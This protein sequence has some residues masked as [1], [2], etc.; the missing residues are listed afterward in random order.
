[1]GIRS[2]KFPLD[3][4]RGARAMSARR[5]ST[6]A[7]AAVVFA[8]VAGTATAGPSQAERFTAA[9]DA[10]LAQPYQPNYV[11]LGFDAA[12]DAAV[13]NTAPVQDYTSGSIPGSA[14]HPD[15]PASFRDVLVK[16]ADGT[17][18]TGKLALRPGT[19][20][21]VVVV[22]GFNTNAKESVVRWA[23]MLARN[24]FNVL[25]A[26]QR[27]FKA[28]HGAGYGYPGPRQTFGWKESEDVLAAGRFLAAQPGVSSVGLVGFSLGGQD[29]VLALALDGAQSKSKRVFSAGMN[30][31]GPS[32][33]STQVYST[34]VP[35][36]C[37]T[38]DC[39][40][41]V[42][43]ALTALVVPPYTYTDACTVLDDAAAYYGA[44]P[45]AILSH[46]NAFHR[47]VKVAV[48]LLNLYSADDSLVAAFEA[49]MMAGY[50]AGNPLQLT[51][52]LE[53]G[54]HA[55][56]FDRWWQQ[57]SILLYFKNLL[58]G[59]TAD[60]TVETGATVNQTPGGASAGS[61]LVDLG[62][63]SRSDADALLAPNPCDT[64]Q[65]APGA[66]MP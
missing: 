58:P 50:E 43:S 3:E 11:P 47:Q 55:Y 6:A 13:L 28:E 9:V 63:P 5:W 2:L 19:H 21:G 25:A 61:Q 22:H 1:M 39:T 51:V 60:P 4:A 64:S 49:R 34:A 53:R 40:Y 8:V 46:E 41:P 36:G 37:E 66:A 20:P 31:S 45:F 62:S 26:D 48:P 15:W 56:F 10:I 18:L 33:Q 54:E 44:S 27:D 59:A 14:D 57:R 29:T 32:D 30:F 7:A 16:S 23:A 65:G 52:Q 35:A 12:F 24:G 42:T 38:P 17:L